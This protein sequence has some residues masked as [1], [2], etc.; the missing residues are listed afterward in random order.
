MPQNGIHYSP[1]EETGTNMKHLGQTVSKSVRF[2]HKKRAHA[3]DLGPSAKRFSAMLQL[4]IRIQKRGYIFFFSN[5]QQ[6]QQ[7][8]F[9]RYHKEG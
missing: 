9:G 2:S 3:G 5:S 6:Q 1:K 7:I 8:L 4:S